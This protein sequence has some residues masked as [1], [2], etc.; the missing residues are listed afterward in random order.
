LLDAD[1]GFASLCV[2]ISA[3]V[4]INVATIRSVVADIMQNKETILP[5]EFQH[6]TIE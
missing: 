2:D 4:G 1:D 3:C 5:P 6:L